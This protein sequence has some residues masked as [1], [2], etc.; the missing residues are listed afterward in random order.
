MVKLGDRIRTA[1]NDWGR[2]HRAFARE[3]QSRGL[4]GGSYRSLLNYM[5]SETTPSG[6]WLEEAAEVLNV[7]LKWLESGEGPRA[8]QV[9]VTD[10]R[11]ELDVMAEFAKCAPREIRERADALTVVS[12]FM[13]VKAILTSASDAPGPRLNPDT[14][15]PVGKWLIEWAGLPAALLN[16]EGGMNQT[17]FNGYFNLFFTAIAA[18][19]PD[20]G[21]G[22]PLAEILDEIKKMEIT[23]GKA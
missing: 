17:R 5:Q 12:W 15:Q 11:T 14:I 9:P 3:M 8:I 19:A 13:A 7:S 2:G 10:P 23:D 16:R 6:K 18:A 22:V 1:V 4:R 21:Q 20:P